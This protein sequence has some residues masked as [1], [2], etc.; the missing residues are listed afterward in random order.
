MGQNTANQSYF[1][2]KPLGVWNH[3]HHDAYPNLTENNNNQQTTEQE[4]RTINEPVHETAPIPDN[5]SENVSE[6]VPEAEYENASPIITKK[7]RNN[8][9]SNMSQQ[10][11]NEKRKEL[12]A[13]LAAVRKAEASSKE[14]NQLLKEEEAIKKREDNLKA[15][16][17]NFLRENEVEPIDKQNTSIVGGYK[18]NSL[19]K[20]DQELERIRL[21]KSKINNLLNNKKY[22]KIGGNAMISDNSNFIPKEINHIVDSPT[23]IDKNVEK[24][25]YRQHLNETLYKLKNQVPLNQ[26]LN[27]LISKFM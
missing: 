24:S 17:A 22:S 21:S 13:R 6:T 5:V 20:I 16:S 27:N 23:S 7:T 18:I 4:H 12:S 3:P 9:S 19:L 2:L 25:E 14:D 10:Q 1:Y 26:N 15:K 8:I 11:R